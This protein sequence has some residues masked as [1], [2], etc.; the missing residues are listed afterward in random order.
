MGTL[1]PRLTTACH[2]VPG[3]AASGRA[4]LGGPDAAPPAG[5]HFVSDAVALA[6]IP[7]NM[8]FKARGPAVAPSGGRS[9]PRIHASPQPSIVP[10]VGPYG[11]QAAAAAPATATEGAGNKTVK[12]YALCGGNPS[13]WAYPSG[14]TYSTTCRLYF[15]LSPTEGQL[16]TGWFI[17]SEHM[18]TA[19]HCVWDTTADAYS[20]YSYGGIYGVVCCAP[21]PSDAFDYNQDGC[22]E[23]AIFWIVNGATTA[24]YANPSNQY[25]ADYDG[26]VVQV[27]RPGATTITI[28][29]LPYGSISASPAGARWV[30]YLGFPAS[31]DSA[32]AGCDVDQY[33]QLNY[34][35]T[36]QPPTPPPASGSGTFLMYNT[37]SCQ[38]MS[39]GP[40]CGSVIWHCHWHFSAKRHFLHFCRPISDLLLPDLVRVSWQ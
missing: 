28:V 13:L 19:G 33:G 36:A 27:Y 11:S 37:S 30:Q 23:S 24:G 21:Q 16:C 40:S 38:G 7:K 17:D 20:V 12:P 26:A 1:T 35:Y 10:P 14:T 22:P 29:P 18:V 6:A 9:A 8:T 34:A 2:G 15:Y 31:Y 3:F 39:G 25:Y 32:L 4:L 5:N